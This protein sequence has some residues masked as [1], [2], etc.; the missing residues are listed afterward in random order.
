MLELS[1]RIAIAVVSVGGSA[2]VSLRHTYRVSRNNNSLFAALTLRAR[3]SSEL[4]D[5]TGL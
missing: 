4:Q 3:P 2:H 1:F 5:A